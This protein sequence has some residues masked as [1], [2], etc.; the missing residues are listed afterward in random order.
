M[1]QK[2]MRVFAGPNGSGKTTIISKLKTEINFG[3]Y[4]NADDIEKALNINGF[5]SLSDYNINITTSDIQAFFRQSDFAPKKTNIENLWQYFS[6]ENDMIAIDKKIT[7]NSYI[8]ADIAD[9]IR[10][11]LLKEEKSFTYETVMSHPEKITFIKKAKTAGYR[12][13]LYFVAT[14]D[15]EIN[16]NRVKVRVAQNGHPVNDEIIRS[17]YY[18]SL[19][20]LKAAVMLTNRAYIFDNSGKVS[21]LLAEVT[22]GTHVEVVDEK[23]LPNWFIQYLT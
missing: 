7:A 4:V 8:A 5:I 17:R 2:R 9:F 22:G 6:V 3:T 14:E 1:P 15:P 12:I 11:Y 23:T 21:E 18:R 20:N 19:G 10:Q 13:Y 16:I